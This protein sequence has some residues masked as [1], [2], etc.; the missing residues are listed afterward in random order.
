VLTWI[1]A[2]PGLPTRSSS[3]SL[4]VILAGPPPAFHPANGLFATTIMRSFA[5]STFAVA[6]FGFLLSACSDS[7]RPEFVSIGTA[8]PGGA[9]FV[10]GGALGEVLNAHAA[11]NNWSVTAESTMGSQ[12]NIARLVQGELDLAMSNAAITYFAVRG[13][14]EWKSPQAVQAV[15]T[16]APNVAL[17][18]TTKGS[19]IT[20]IAELKNKRVVIGPPGA[21]FES[22]VAPILEAHGVGLSDL[23]PLYATQNGAVDML[24]DGSASAIFIGGAIPT[25]SISQAAVSQDIVFLPFDDEAK[26]A[27]IRD[28]AFFH[29]ATI[30]G[31]TYRGVEDDF[32]GLNVGSMHVICAAAGD[33]ELIYRITKTLYENREEIVAKHPAGNAINPQNVIRH[34]GTDFHPG[35]IRY[36][37]EAGLWKEADAAE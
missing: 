7:R 31:K 4:R 34:T 1:V 27:L 37:R 15:M 14:G 16:L 10:V 22:F 29:P 32:H 28:Y 30:P 25:A 33:E 3:A 12:E 20:S 9:F 19:G 11:E 21:G 35:A 23:T 36:Y 26:S 2:S 8:P 18:V 5:L 17:F 13:Q 6:A 24:A